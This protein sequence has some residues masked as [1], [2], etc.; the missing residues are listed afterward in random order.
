[1][2]FIRPVQIAVLTIGVLIAAVYSMLMG[3]FSFVLNTFL[4][5]N[6]H[7]HPWDIQN[8]T[9]FLTVVLGTVGIPFALEMARTLVQHRVSS[10]KS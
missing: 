3:G 2:N 7:G 1:M 10:T 8:D 9:F 4:R 6:P 5:F